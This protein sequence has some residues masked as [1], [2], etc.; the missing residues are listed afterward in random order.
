MRTTFAVTVAVLLPACSVGASQATGDL[1]D[2]GTTRL[3]TSPA[4]VEMEVSS[5]RPMIQLEV[6]G[7]GPYRFV[8]DT[9][10]GLSVIDDGI[11][12]ELGLEVVGS[13]QLQSPGSPGRIQGRRVRAARLETGPLTIERPTLATMDLAAYS[14][15]TIDGVLGRPHFAGL[16]LTLDYPNARIVLAE[17]VLDPGSPEVMAMDLS[18]GSVRVA[19]DL[20]GRS[21]PM[22]IDS[23]SPGGFSLPKAL[24][25]ELALRAP[26][27][28]GPTIDLVG[29]SHESWK[30]ELDGTIVLGEQ[31]YDE[32][33]IT[34]VSYADD[35]GNIGMQVLRELRVTLDQASSLIAFARPGA[36]GEETGTER[37]LVEG[38]PGA[39]G[40]VRLGGAQQPGGPGGP[41]RLGVRFGMTP[42]GFVRERGGLVV[43]DV[44]RGGSA[45]AAGLRAGDILVEVAGQPLADVQRVAELAALLQA[46]RP[47][48]MVVVRGDERLRIEVP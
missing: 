34:L 28:P 6:N 27:Q 14:A 42:Q 15:G 45:E 24:E 7:Q 16:L 2:P 3:A 31:R 10:A 46:P 40:P 17:G 23:G 11:A 20:A 36:V 44:D 41:P 30:A 1:P 29:G 12:T 43:Q 13:Q 39:G 9:G 33:R 32:P 38:A 19:I 8:V 21:F 4:T 18:A 48:E 37:R 22:V 25:P 47:I 26:A 35:F 5:G